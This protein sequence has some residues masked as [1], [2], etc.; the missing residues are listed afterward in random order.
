MS[1][2]NAGLPLRTSQEAWS[3]SAEKRL[4]V[5][6][7]P[8][9]SSFWGSPIAQRT[10]VICLR[11]Q[12]HWQRWNQNQGLLLAN[13]LIVTIGNKALSLILLISRIEDKRILSSIYSQVNISPPGLEVSLELDLGHSKNG[14]MR[15]SLLAHSSSP[16]THVN[17][18][19]VADQTLC[20]WRE[21]GD[22][23][24][25]VPK[26]CVDRSRRY[27]W[28]DRVGRDPS[29]H[30]RMFAGQPCAGFQGNTK[31]GCVA[32]RGV[33]SGKFLQRCHFIE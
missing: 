28:P 24:F 10:E 29:Q 15:S 23:L 14:E 3:S 32:Q 5:L 13:V 17:C 33:R 12:N 2:Y 26:R 7:G 1:N 22:E 30:I 21:Y 18:S 9:P 11:S 20:G 31:G 4:Y 19:S 8:A 6:S 25:S 27:P 16:W